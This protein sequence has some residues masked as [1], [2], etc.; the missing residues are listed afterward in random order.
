[1]IN[2]KSLLIALAAIA[3]Q[4]LSAQGIET[5][6][7]I[8]DCGQVTYRQPVAAEFELR[9]TSKH[10]V[11]ITRVEPSCGCVVTDYPKTEIPAD[12][13]FVVRLTYD[14]MQMG[15]FNRFADV[16]SSD[17][18]EALTLMM[19]GIVVNEVVDYSGTYPFK[20]GT[21]QA[22]M[23]NIEFDDVYSGERPQQS[24]HIRNVGTETLQ[25]VAMHLPDYLSAEVSPSKIAPGRSGV[26]TFTLKST[27]LP[28][29]GLTQTKIYL[30]AKPGDKVS[31]DKEIGV[32]AVLL[33][34]F[35]NMTEREL[36][37]APLMRLSTEQLDLRN[38]SGKKKMKGEITIMNEGKSDLRINNLQ[39][40]T[41]GVSL[42]LNKAVIEPGQEAKLKVTADAKLLKTIGREP[43][44]LIITNDPNK[45]K[46][47]VRILI[48]D[49]QRVA[50]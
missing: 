27:E 23:N 5:L 15:H 7:D 26:V 11:R 14:A 31:S 28:D 3:A 21:I 8:V 36:A 37:L 17:G 47:I 39:M 32:S 40:F 49:K 13:Q 25:P 41:E 38:L 46:V 34:T 6:S 43:R 22:D 12:G 50:R 4:G 18:D 42:S 29:L 48:S 33:P 45:P 10:N 16:Y 19:K 1:M 9:N 2:K 24:I 30:G 35:N 20:I 44:I